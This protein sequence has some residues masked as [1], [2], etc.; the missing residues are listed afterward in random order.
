MGRKGGKKEQGKIQHPAQRALARSLLLQPLLVNE[1][2]NRTRI[3]KRITSDCFFLSVRG[4]QRRGR[5]GEGERRKGDGKIA[6]DEFLQ[7]QVA[8]EMSRDVKITHR[9]RPRICKR[10]C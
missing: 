7:L 1:C 8:T 6:A 2:T 4:E 9:A 10:P 5:Q 3:R